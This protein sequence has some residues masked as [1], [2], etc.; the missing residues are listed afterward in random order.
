MSLS[1]K[2]FY[3]SN[4]GHEITHINTLIIH[5]PDV[6]ECDLCG[7][8]YHGLAEKIKKVRQTTGWFFGIL[9]VAV[10]IVL[11]WWTS[12]FSALIG[13]FPIFI[14]YRFYLNNKVKKLV[15]F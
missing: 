1:S 5:T 6:V 8:K 7:Q 15:N 10:F 12:I 13:L 9:A 14:I 3:C 2:Y 11:F 4:C